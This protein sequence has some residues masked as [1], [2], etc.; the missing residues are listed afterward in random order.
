M[1]EK[2]WFLSLTQPDPTRPLFI[3]LPG[4]DGTALSMHQQLA[5]LQSTFDL[6][7]LSIPVNDRTPWSGFID[8]VVAHVKFERHRYPDRPLYLCGESFGGC[9]ALQVVAKIPT[10]FSGLVII[11]AGSALKQLFWHTWMPMVVDQMS[12]PV[13]H[14]AA[15]ILLPLLVDAGRVTVKNR[16]GL[17]AAIKAIAPTTAAW[18]LALLRDAEIEG[19]SLQSFTAPTLLIASGQDQL[20]PSVTEAQRLTTYFP[21]A[22]LITLAA[23][24]HACLLEQDV[25]LGA[26]LNQTPG[27]THLDGLA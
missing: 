16:E 2:L 13:Y 22:Q 19:R 6:R 1:A 11:N 25:S 18:R 4:M 21:Q 9:L 15:D 3:F 12:V 14:M 10:L 23:S 27:F 5:G 26:I 24:S 8:Q 17:L 20:L 7:Y